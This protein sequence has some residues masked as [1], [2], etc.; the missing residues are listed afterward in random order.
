MT[1]AAKAIHAKKTSERRLRLRIADLLRRLDDCWSLNG[2][3]VNVEGLQQSQA[4]LRELRSL[5]AGWEHGRAR[6]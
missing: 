3:S 5:T 6:A 1:N 2:T 4:E